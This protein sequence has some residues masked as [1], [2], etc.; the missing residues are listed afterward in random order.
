MFIIPFL[1][2][3]VSLGPTQITVI[4]MLLVGGTT[5]WE[6]EDSLELQEILGPNGICVIGPPTI[7]GKM[8]FCPVDPLKTNLSDFYQW[9][10]ISK[11]DHETICWRTYYLVGEKNA[12]RSWLPLPKE[13]LG[14]YTCQEVLDTME[15]I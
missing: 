13:K 7:H 2:K 11:E 12:Y 1:R 9:S 5:L 14:Q 10:E 8:V 3:K 6:E 4:Q 15:S